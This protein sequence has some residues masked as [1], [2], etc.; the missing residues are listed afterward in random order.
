MFS[1]GVMLAERKGSFLSAGIIAP[2]DS[3]K[4][5]GASGPKYKYRNRTAVV[6]GRGSSKG[7]VGFAS[8]DALG[9]ELS[10]CQFLDSLSY[11]RLR[12]MLHVLDPVEV[13]VPESVADNGSFK[14]PIVEMLQNSFPDIEV[15]KI[16]RRFFND[17][18]GAELIQQL[19]SSELSHLT[20]DMFK[21]YYCMSAVS[22]LIKYIEYIQNILFAHASLKITYYRM[23]KTCFIDVNT[24]KNIE[25]IRG[26]I[27]NRKEQ[28]LSLFDF[29]NTCSTSGGTRMLRSCLF[30]PSADVDLI[31][32]RSNAVEELLSNQPLTSIIQ[33]FERL[34]AIIGNAGDIQQLITV[35]CYMNT[36]FDSIRCTEQKISEVLCLRQT[37]LLI[38][39]L[40]LALE[41][42]TAQIFKTCYQHLCDP[43]F[44][45]ISEKLNA[46]LDPNVMIHERTSL[47]NRYK[48]CYAIR[49][50]QHVMVDLAR[51]AYEELVRDVEEKA[52][53]EMA[54]LSGARLIFTTQRGFHI[55]VPSMNPLCPV[56]LPAPFIQVVRNRSS[57]SCTT[58]SLIK[59]NDRIN[60][61]V[62][63][64]M[65]GSNIV[66][67]Q[68]MEEIR[69]LISCLYHLVEVVSLID[70]LMCL[71]TYAFKVPTVKPTFA[72]SNAMV[73][74]QGRHPL[75]DMISDNVIAN[76]AYLSPESRL[77]I[78]T[79]PNMAG[80]S[81]YLKQLCLLQVLAQ[82]GS[83]VPAEFAGFPVVQRI[84]SRI[85]HN[86]DLTNNLSS[87]ALEMSEMA[88]IFAAADSTSLVVVDELARH[89]Y[90]AQ[91]QLEILDT[92]TEEGIALCFGF[93]E[94]MLKTKAFVV[95]ATHFL[96]LTSLAANFATVENYHFSATTYTYKVP[97]KDEVQVLKCNHHLYKGPYRGPL[98]GFNIAE[99]GNF[100]KGLLDEAKSFA[101]KLRAG[102]QTASLMSEESRRRR[103]V[104]R[105]GYKLRSMLPILKVADFAAASSYL[106]NLRQQ[107]REDL[108][109]IHAAT[110]ERSFD[111]CAGS[112]ATGQ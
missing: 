99:L 27:S 46:R 25:V 9:S 106:I 110:N 44:D 64:I 96:D 40:K 60:D 72:A 36:T 34:R 94:E 59:Y 23:E 11:A 47:A 5:L 79:G 78:I 14:N 15:T 67:A 45:G 73:I 54:C 71:A 68:L 39:P 109:E 86:D 32:D 52:K 57:V 91:Q 87:F 33:K 112:T 2:T 53:E 13:I 24:L 26:R 6:E 43:R 74:K 49:S 82:T 29:L 3:R 10:I 66:I 102:K 98:Y 85:G 4:S 62:N 58:R 18:R 16:S 100:P 1:F 21:K 22:A 105:F 83:Y 20:R 38:E 80:K 56:K 61:A 42:S 30:Q 77:V 76:D 90:F 84:F 104:L 111:R 41:S 75:L 37:I 101:E 17:L 31:L 35:C 95:F 70:F 63:E 107:L 69:P 81:T 92:A 103:A 65:V 8:M 19:G 108:S 89:A 51:K 50:G 12:V 7:E 55:L 97:D 88:P 93:C 28:N 48:R